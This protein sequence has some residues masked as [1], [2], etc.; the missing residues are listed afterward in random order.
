VDPVEKNL[1]TTWRPQR[2]LVHLEV[3]CESHRDRG[4]AIH[5]YCKKFLI[6][7]IEDRIAVGR[8][9]WVES[10]EAFDDEPRLARE[11]A[12]ISGIKGVRISGT[13]TRSQRSWS[14]P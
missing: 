2:W 12:R 10:V 6:L 5:R 7:Q 14:K 13:D 4:A 9:T 8:E 1:T 11:S 3:P